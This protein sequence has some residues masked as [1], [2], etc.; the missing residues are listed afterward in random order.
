M[1]ADWEVE[2]GGDAAVL[3]AGWAGFVDLGREPHRVSEL[4]EVRDFAPLGTALLRLNAAGSP[5]DTAKCDVWTAE[6]WPDADEMDAAGEV[7]MAGVACYVDLLAR[8]P[9]TTV[10]AAVAVARESAQMLARAP[11]SGARIDLVV[12]LA[13]LADGRTAYGI[14]AYVQAAAAEAADARVRL[15]AALAQLAETVSPQTAAAPSYLPI[16]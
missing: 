12:R 13:V 2:V 4:E 9:W 11:Q 15:A 6:E 10:E 5:V 16:Q 3:D 8:T 14:T 1:N 7:L